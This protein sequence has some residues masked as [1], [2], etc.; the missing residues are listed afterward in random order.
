MAD[1]TTKDHKKGPA[2]RQIRFVIDQHPRGS[3]IVT[4]RKPSNALNLQ[5]QVEESCEEE[6]D[7]VFGPGITGPR[8]SGVTRVKQLLQSP[9]PRFGFSPAL[10]GYEASLSAQEDEAE[11]EEYL[12]PPALTQFPNA[13]AETDALYDESTCVWSCLGRS[14]ARTAD[15]TNTNAGD[16]KMS[17]AFGLVLSYLVDFVCQPADCYSRC[18]RNTQDSCSDAAEHQ[19]EQPLLKPSPFLRGEYQF[20]R[21]YQ[22]SQPYKSMARPEMRIVSDDR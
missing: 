10:S 11:R 15:G 2:N 12:R 6:D 3:C 17:S 5:N 14:P 16:G 19:D 18:I 4:P 8:L 7:D 9:F 1:T 22:A 21:A 20:R 13:H